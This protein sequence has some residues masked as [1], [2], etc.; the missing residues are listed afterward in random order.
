M[1]K[2]KKM[3]KTS[4]A[5]IILAL[6]LVLSLAF[7]MTG[8]WF[9][10]KEV[11]AQNPV[12][13]MGKVDISLTPNANG[14]F[15]VYREDGTTNV[16]LSS[17]KVY[18]GDILKLDLGVDNAADSDEFWFV[19]LITVESATK[20]TGND[21]VNLIANE[22]VVE[23]ITALEANNAKLYCT[24]SNPA[25]GHDHSAV[26][27]VSTMEFELDGE[28]WGN[29]LQEADITLKYE[30]RAIQYTNI[31]ADEAYYYLNTGYNEAAF[32]NGTGALAAPANTQEPSA[33]PEPGNGGE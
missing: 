11:P 21:Q 7:G 33:D 28:K 20:G 6:L 9:T 2:S 16:N 29:A 15:A 3:S 14:A 5:V 12:I 19:V 23:L 8:A 4:I 1:V 25:A 27:Y 18:P 32:T 31:D 24:A 13:H 26:A 17:A 10:D 22:Q 30:V